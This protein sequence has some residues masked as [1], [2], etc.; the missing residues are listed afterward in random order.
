MRRGDEVT[1]TVPTHRVDL[2]LAEDLYEEALRHFGYDNI[3][4]ALPPTAAPPGKR[5][6]SWPLTERGRDALHAA[7]L[8]EAVTYSFIAPELE[9]ATAGTPLTNRGD[10]VELANPLSARQTVMRRS[11]LGGLA[12]AAAGNLRRGAERVMLGEVGRAFFTT[13]GEV[14]EGERLAVVLAGRAGGW[15]HSRPFDFLDLK[16]ILEGVLEALGVSAPAWRPSGSIML[17]AGEGA[18]VVAGDQVIGVA[19]R[20]AEAVAALVAAPLPLWVGELDLACA[21]GD[22]VPEFRPLPR[23]PAVIADLTVRHSLALAYDELAGALRAAA[24]T[25]LEE[26]A[27]VARYHGEGVAADEVKTTL[28]LVYRHGERSLTQDEVN[29]AHFALMETLTRQLGVSFT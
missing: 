18:E 11:L 14:R 27:P 2:E 4:P 5:L 23:H 10:A 6:G 8:A 29:A 20:L 13:G 22:V 19:G 7:G 9:T 25:W 3:P 28:R 21:A 17:A 26:I 15:D 24:P 1:C 16:G 12:E